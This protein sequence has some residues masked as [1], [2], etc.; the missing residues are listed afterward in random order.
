MIPF[1]LPD[2]LNERK[3]HLVGAKGTGMCALAEILKASGASVS[4]SDT[5]DVFYTDHI[6]ASLGVVVHDFNQANI[7]E[8]IDLVVHSAAYRA[9]SHPELVH[10]KKLGIPIITYPEALGAFSRTMDSSGICGVHGKTTT[11]A[12]AGTVAQACGLPATILAGSAVSGFGDRSTLILGSELFIAETCEYRR[13]FLSFSP[14]RIVLTSVEPDHQDYYPD[15]ASIMRAFLEYTLLLPPGGTL[16]YCADD[17]GASELTRKLLELRPDVLV[18]PYGF[19]AEGRFHISDYRVHDERAHFF[20]AGHPV[21]W[22]LRLPGRY[23]ALDAAA[24]IALCTIIAD[25]IHRPLDSSD[26]LAIAHALDGFAGSRRRSELIGEARGV[27]IMDDYA[28]HPTAI[29]TTLAGLREFYPNRRLV[30]DFMSHT[31]SRTKA[32][33]DDFASAFVAADETILHRIY[34]SARE[35]PDP[36]VSGKGLFQAVQASGVAAT[37]FEN[38]LEATDYLVARLCPG[39]LFITMGAGD[40]WQLGRVVYEHLKAGETADGKDPV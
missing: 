23:L 9:D 18:V 21:P 38:P 12:L 40:N 15:L 25:D 13:H 14:H 17:T 31:A 7:N 27:L 26:Y 5:S 34:P 30:V 28:H 10:A 19:T 35:A 3:I 39:D 6:L 24:A 22:S 1:V 37:Y 11:T 36:S 32:L 8:D 4:G 29:K 2:P 16:I 20:L 33:F